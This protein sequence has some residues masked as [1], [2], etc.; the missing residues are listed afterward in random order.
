MFHLSH[1]HFRNLVDGCP[2]AH[3]YWML[4]IVLKSWTH[5]GIEMQKVFAAIKHP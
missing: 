5:M 3:M 1:L 2:I 4:P